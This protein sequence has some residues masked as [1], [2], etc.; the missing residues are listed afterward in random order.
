MPLLPAA[1]P[2]ELRGDFLR[3][4]ARFG[5][6]LLVAMAAAAAPLFGELGEMWPAIAALEGWAFL[7]AATLLGAALAGIPLL[8][9]VGLALAVWYGVESVYQPRRRVS[10]A[11]DKLILALGL[12]V[13]FGPALALLAAAARA[14]ATGR[15]HFMRPPRD[16]FLAT[17]PIAFWQGV[18]FWLIVAA[19]LGYLAWRYWRGKLGAST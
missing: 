2:D 11:L 17:D 10:P 5:L 14:V 16:Y 12:V 15:I 3:R 9:L 18:G 8:A 7:G 1:R 4:R 6:V 13:W 19:G